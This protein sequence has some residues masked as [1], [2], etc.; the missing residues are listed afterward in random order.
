MDM[1]KP[2]LNTTNTNLATRAITQNYNMLVGKPN[3]WIIPKSGT[4]GQVSPYV[5]QLL[6]YGKQ[7][8]ICGTEFPGQNLA[9]LDLAAQRAAIEDNEE[10]LVL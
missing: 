10:Y 9:E 4:T 3:A 6:L 1:L 8:A 5:S 2:G 7:E